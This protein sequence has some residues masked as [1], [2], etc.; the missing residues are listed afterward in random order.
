VAQSQ[1]CPFCVALSEPFTKIAV[2]I[3]VVS[4]VIDTRRRLGRRTEARVRSSEVRC[5]HARP[6]RGPQQDGRR[7]VQSPLKMSAHQRQEAL[8]RT[9]ARESVVDISALIRRPHRGGRTAAVFGNLFGPWVSQYDPCG[10]VA[11]HLGSL[12][13]S[14]FQADTTT[15]P[16]LC[17]HCPRLAI[18]L[19]P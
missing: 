16:H 18:C 13:N 15:C 2:R 10:G 9:D 14:G 12:P 19:R 8:Q 4:S 17:Q 11:L 7:A 6:W 3:F 5:V 1:R